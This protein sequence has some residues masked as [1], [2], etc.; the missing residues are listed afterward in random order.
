MATPVAPSVA[1]SLT[2]PLIPKSQPFLQREPKAVYPFDNA[3][4]DADVI[5]QTADGTMFYLHWPIMRIASPLY[6]D[7]SRLPQPPNPNTD[8]AKSSLP[9]VTIEESAE[10]FDRLLRMCYPVKRPMFFNVPSVG[11]VLSA[12]MKYQMAEPKAILTDFLLLSCP[13]DPLPVY[14]V[15][16]VHRLE[17]VARRAAETSSAYAASDYTPTMDDIPTASYYKLLLNYW[18][19][20]AKPPAF[21]ILVPEFCSS[22]PPK[23]VLSGQVLGAKFHPFDDPKHGD[24][25]LRSADGI[26][27]HAHAHMLSYAS[28]VFRERFSSASTASTPE[29]VVINAS[30]SSLI[31][32]A[33]VR[34][35]YPLPDPD[36][37]VWSSDGDRL[38]DLCYLFD[39]A[40]KYAAVRAQEFAKR[41]C[42]ESAQK[43]PLRLYLIASHYGWKGIAEAAALRA[44]YELVDQQVPEMEFVRAATYRRFLVYREKC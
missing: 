44:I 5:F 12:A 6:R 30:E 32:A 21:A 16:C 24:T 25:I 31:L 11:P 42:V 29:R 40:N 3:N 10:T 26:D 9:I 8:T 1:T 38:N 2:G 37:S 13:N 33:L 19:R 23:A 15:A 22:A 41:A 18:K 27:L 28:P 34:F 36:L 39:A 4:E 17:L 35:C 7:M 43:T 14:A 20:T